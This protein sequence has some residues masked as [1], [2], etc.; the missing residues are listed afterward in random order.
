MSGNGPVNGPSG[1]VSAGWGCAADRSV[2]LGKSVVETGLWPL[3]EWDRGRVK[4]NR[5][6]KTFAPLETYLK[7]Q[8]RFRQLGP[9]EI[10][11]LEAGRDKRWA[12]LRAWARETEDVQ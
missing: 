2:E 11:A 3:A 4:I 10:A 9:E 1:L 5:A 6:P 12:A 8:A 7:G